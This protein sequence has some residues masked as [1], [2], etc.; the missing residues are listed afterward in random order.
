MQA[1]V[2]VS[3]LGSRSG[4][5]GKNAGRAFALM[6]EG[7]RL[8]NRS[9]WV[10]Q[11]ENPAGVSS[12]ANTPLAVLPVRHAACVAIARCLKDEDC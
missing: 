9:G 8:G 3:L 11:R 10:D 6:S 7:L 2:G 1:E 12:P 5:P 4:A